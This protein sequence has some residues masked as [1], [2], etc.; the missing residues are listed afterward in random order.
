MQMGMKQYNYIRAKAVLNVV[1]NVYVI[2]LK[3][4][5]NIVMITILVMVVVLIVIIKPTTAMA[6][7][8][9]V[10]TGNRYVVI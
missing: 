3:V 4:G 5:G 7:Q 2:E 1:S 10:K 6:H 9:D 8:Q